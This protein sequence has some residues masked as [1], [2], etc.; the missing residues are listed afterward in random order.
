MKTLTIVKIGGKIVDDAEMLNQALDSFSKIDSPKILVHG[1]GKRASAMCLKL[2]IAPEMKDGR[3]VTNVETLEV[4][5]MVYAGLIN[6]TLVS[7]LQKY[8]CN[9]FGCSGADGNLIIAQKRPVKEVDFGFAGDIK[10]INHT[11]FT[12]LL[13]L[14]ITPVFCA[15]THDGQGQLLNTNADTIAAHIA[16]V[17]TV[18]FDVV[19][20]YCFEKMGVLS[21]PKDD[22]SSIPTLSHTDYMHLRQQGTISAGMIPKLDNAFSAKQAH[23][24]NVW[25]CGIQGITQAAETHQTGTEICL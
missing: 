22:S 12:Q 25:I 3:R 4:A 7:Q 14:G 20:K 23:V 13:A 21:N 19:L 24:Q 10:T 17:M 18:H 8:D 5:T 2:G 15:I 9:A 11:L 16:S 1:G 6:K